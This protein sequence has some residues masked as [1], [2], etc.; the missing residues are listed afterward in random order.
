MRALDFAI[1][2]GLAMTNRTRRLTLLDAVHV[3]SHSKSWNGKVMRRALASA[4]YDDA[5]ICL[6]TPAATNTIEDAIRRLADE[7]HESDAQDDSTLTKGRDEH[8]SVVRK[9]APKEVTIQ[10]AKDFIAQ[11]SSSDH[12]QW[13]WEQRE[14]CQQ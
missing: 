8:R 12:E 5:L 11:V 4:P 14:H 10:Q 6:T 2:V 13:Q 3:I 7:A 9:T 1:D